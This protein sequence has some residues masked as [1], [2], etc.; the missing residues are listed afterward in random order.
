ME[1]TVTKL[2][3]ANNGSMNV[4]EI[5]AHFRSNC[6]AVREVISNRDKFCFVVYNGDQRVLAKTNVRLCRSQ[7]CHGCRN[8][9]FC[10]RLL[11]GECPFVQR[12][13]GCH[14]SHELTSGDNRSILIEHGLE[15]LDRAELCTLLLQNDHFL[16]PPVCHDYN[17]S[18]GEYGKC[19]D[20]ETC[21]RLHIC[22]TYLRGSCNCGRCHD[23]YE[24]HPFKT[25]QDKGVPIKLIGSLKSAY[26]NLEWLQRQYHAKQSKQH[27]QSAKADTSA[28]TCNQSNQD[29][30]TSHGNGNNV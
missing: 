2:I 15:K 27:K 1:S 22:E 23:F 19:K 11:F 3:C 26:M 29:P 7:N 5:Y 4:E 24:P 13:G 8:L 9:H 16:L 12:R 6:L 10:K 28:N 30:Y 14:F 17:N 18:A 21:K 20:G 25:L